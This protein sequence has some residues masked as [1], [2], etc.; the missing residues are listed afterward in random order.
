[1]KYT[2]WGGNTSRIK[3]FADWEMQALKSLSSFTSMEHRAP[4][5]RAVH[6][7]MG[8]GRRVVGCLNWQ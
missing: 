7:V 4:H 1:M 5:V 6:M 3:L 2:N 8:L